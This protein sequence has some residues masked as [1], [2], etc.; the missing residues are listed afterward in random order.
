MEAT[1]VESRTKALQGREL[2]RKGEVVKEKEKD[3]AFKGTKEK[4]DHKA[5]K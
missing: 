5:E 4:M 2:G 1:R 3:K